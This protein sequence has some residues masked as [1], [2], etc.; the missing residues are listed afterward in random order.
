[1][2]GF[3]AVYISISLVLIFS[4]L[5]NYRWVSES[6]DLNQG[7]YSFEIT[8][9]VSRPISL[10]SSHVYN[11]SILLQNLGFDDNFEYSLV[12]KLFDSPILS[13]MSD[14]LL[15]HCIYWI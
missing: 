11:I 8:T 4:L 7:F 2:F 1:M 5:D 6:H 15:L 9:L 14:C 12:L 3:S 10:S 13:V